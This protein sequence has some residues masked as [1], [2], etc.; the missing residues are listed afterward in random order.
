MHYSP[1][2]YS[3]FANELSL[4]YSEKLASYDDEL[5]KEAVVKF[6][7]ST[8]PMRALA[9]KYPALDMPAVQGLKQVKHDVSPSVVARR[10]A[11]SKNPFVQG[12]GDSM[13]HHL[14]HS[15]VLSR[16]GL[17]GTIAAGAVQSG[18]N[19]ARQGAARLGGRLANTAPAGSFRARAGE[20]L[21]NA[22]LSRAA[23]VTTDKVLPGAAHLGANM[24]AA[25]Q[26]P[27]AGAL[28]GKGLTT[29][30]AKAV[31]VNGLT[32][33][34]HGLAELASHAGQDVLGD[35]VIGRLAAR[36]GRRGLAA[37]AS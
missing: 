3:A 24:A 10:M 26:I 19:L 32:S 2:T 13:G 34:G 17:P 31:G 21:A 7:A 8:R 29:L 22:S 27:M 35:K 11:Q 1:A 28:V 30:G 9:K 16:L 23:R 18:G 20:G 25:T 12:M 5:I 14:S 33:A 36:L 6:L 4:L 15:P 37:A